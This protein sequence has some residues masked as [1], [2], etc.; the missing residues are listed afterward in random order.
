[1]DAFPCPCNFLSWSFFLAGCC[2]TRRYSRGLCIPLNFIYFI[3]ID[4]I[5]VL[6]VLCCKCT[7]LL[8]VSSFMTEFNGDCYISNFDLNLDLNGIVHEVCIISC[9]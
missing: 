7:Y 1:M 9:S 3:M 6:V 5:D 4:F 8:F 2:S